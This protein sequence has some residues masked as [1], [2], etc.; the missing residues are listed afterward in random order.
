MGT[1]GPP[2]S[3]WH[4]LKDS[5]DLR[6]IVGADYGN[7]QPEQP[8]EVPA[9]ASREE[10]RVFNFDWSNP[11]EAEAAYVLNWRDSTSGAKTLRV[12]QTD[13]FPPSF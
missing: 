8:S 12:L 1:Q 3:V 4:Y 10:Y 13:R 7:S 2:L 11:V 9:G 5:G 6:S